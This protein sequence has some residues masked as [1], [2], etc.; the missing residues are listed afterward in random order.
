MS[1]RFPHA[2]S[3]IL[4]NLSGIS[5]LGSHHFISTPSPPLFCCVHVTDMLFSTGSCFEDGVMVSSEPYRWLWKGGCFV[6]ERMGCRVCLWSAC[7]W[8]AFLYLIYTLKERCPILREMLFVGI[9]SDT[10]EPHSCTWCIQACCTLFILSVINEVAGYLLLSDYE[11][12]VVFCKR[13]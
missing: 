5:I 10:P 12:V 3:E 6:F 2:H 9:G 11:F 4:F 13:Y 1:W 8:I 7:E